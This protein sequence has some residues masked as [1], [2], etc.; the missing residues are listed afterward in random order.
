MAISEMTDRWWWKGL[1]VSLA[2]WI[3]WSGSPC[4]AQSLPN[5]GVESIDPLRN[6]SARER[7]GLIKAIA[8]QLRPYMSDMNIKSEHELR[9]V[10]AEDVE[11]IP[12]RGVRLFLVRMIGTKLCGAVGNCS[13]WVFRKHGDEYSVI[14]NGIAQMI[15]IQPTLT[16]GVHDL[17]VETHISADEEGSALYRFNGTKYVAK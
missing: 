7:A 1:I 9:E 2:I 14:L 5:V 13:F 4:L 6:L 16:N 11:A 3:C 12:G 15:T 8:S 17:L 10:A